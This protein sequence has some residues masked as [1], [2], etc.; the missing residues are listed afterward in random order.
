MTVWPFSQHVMVIVDGSSCTDP[1][2]GHSHSPHSVAT[3][4][5]IDSDFFDAIARILR[6]GLTLAAVVIGHQVGLSV[7]DEERRR[8]ARP[9]TRAQLLKKFVAFEFV[10]LWR[11]TVE[12]EHAIAIVELAAL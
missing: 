4:I 6:C 8:N 3:V 10:P 5:S 2:V 11:Y 1:H 7:D 9:L 12:I